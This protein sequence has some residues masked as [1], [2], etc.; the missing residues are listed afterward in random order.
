MKRLKVAAMVAAIVGAFWFA[1]DA[2]YQDA[3]RGANEYRLNVCAGAW[4]DYKGQRPAC[5]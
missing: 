2:D 3:K 4:P 5:P 1:G